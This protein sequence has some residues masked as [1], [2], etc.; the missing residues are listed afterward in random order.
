MRILTIIASIVLIMYGLIHLMGTTGY[1][2]L[3]EIKGL[4]YKTT[5]LNGR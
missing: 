2:K 3:A 5:V 1:V 4:P